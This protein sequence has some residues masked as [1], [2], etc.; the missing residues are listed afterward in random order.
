MMGRRTTT[1]LVVAAVG[2]VGIVRCA[3][4][5]DAPSADSD[6]RTDL[7]V[8]SFN[9]RYGTAD[10]GGNRWDL[11]RDLVVETIRRFGPDLLGTQ[12]CLDFQGEFLREHLP[13]H[14]FIGVGRDDGE[15]AGEMCAV[16]FR[17]DRFER[18]DSGTFWL[19]ET[20]DSPGSRGWDAALPRIATWV[21]L[22]DRHIDAD[23]VFINTH[24]DHRGEAAR[25][26]SA[27]M[28]GR[29]AV[30]IADGAP[31]V[32]TG[33]FNAPAVMGAAEPYQALLREPGADTLRFL[34]T[35]RAIYPQPAAH[36]GT[37]GDFTG[38]SDGSRIDWILIS[39]DL[40]T[41]AAAID[42][43]RRD[44][45]WPSDHFPVTATIR[46]IGAN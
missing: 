44:G 31:I 23:I 3:A 7:R 30:E 24:F 2:I 21:R 5:P 33:D 9:I 43:H 15:L 1:L 13:D 6:L 8:M 41:V 11:R 39:R 27:R 46:R 45:K 18:I 28:L 32:I 25:L 36:E 12:E 29:R 14:E 20:P 40:R 4:P 26:E 10:D 42:R 16:F 19:S 34:D 35:Y 17:R 22:R 38:A 37:F